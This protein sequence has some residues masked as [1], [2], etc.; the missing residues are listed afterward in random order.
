[1]NTPEFDQALF[2]FIANKVAPRIG[3]GGMIVAGILYKRKIGALHE[4]M[5][6]LGIEDAMGVVDLGK[7]RE[8]LDGAL[9]FVQSPFKEIFG[10]YLEEMKQ[11]L[12]A[13]EKKA[14]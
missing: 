14:Q 7:L 2:T 1:M 12:L 9:M 11:F 5:R 4:G 6:M 3:L 8:S 13:M 10:Q